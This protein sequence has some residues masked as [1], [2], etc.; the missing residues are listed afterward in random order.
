[1]VHVGSKGVLQCG[2][3]RLATPR[4]L[5]A[6]LAPRPLTCCRKL[7][8]A[9]NLSVGL[10]L[11]DDCSRT[12]KAFRGLRTT[13][14]SKLDN[15]IV[16]ETFVNSLVR[17]LVVHLDEPITNADDELIVAQAAAPQIP[18]LKQGIFPDTTQH[19]GTLLR[20]RITPPEA[21]RSISL[22]LPV[23]L[24]LDARQ[25]WAR[26][27]VSFKFGQLVASCQFTDYDPVDELASTFAELLR[28]FRPSARDARALQNPWRGFGGAG[29][30]DGLWFLASA[31][32][33]RRARARL[34][35]RRQAQRADALPM[36][37]GQVERNV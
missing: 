7:S 37:R 32:F 21:P 16:L 31:W 2:W 34:H 33:G 29:F 15:F 19:V 20:R 24:D 36:Q 17:S 8:L 26:H 11:A 3:K 28:I 22:G 1:M 14:E 6:E 10:V 5:V 18:F 25:L 30:G 13:N 23:E 4:G 12:C 35:V 9:F 27:A